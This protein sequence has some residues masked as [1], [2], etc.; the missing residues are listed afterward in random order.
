D[1][2]VV[3]GGFCYPQLA[4]AVQDLDGEAT[5]VENT[6]LHAGN[7]LSLT[8]GLTAIP[9][10]AGFLL[11][12][13]DHIYPKAVA[14]IVSKT[15]QEAKEITAFCDFDRPLGADDMKARFD[16]KGFVTAMAKTLDTWDGGYVG[17]TWI[18]ADRRE[19]YDDAI[20]RLRATSGDNNAVERVLVTLAEAKT[21]PTHADISGH[22][23]F[24][25]DE[26]H[27]RDAAEAGLRAVEIE[28]VGGAS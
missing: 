15:A 24:E 1:Q 4:D 23:W 28:K 13:A 18:P 21:P 19:A 16:D 11:M 22:R 9:G 2:R 8:A 12:N 7:L 5:L 20:A 26:P 3:V 25:V 27:E 10:K 17:M 6:E 14:D